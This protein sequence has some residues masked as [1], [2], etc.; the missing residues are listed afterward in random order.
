MKLFPQCTFTFA[1]CGEG[2]KGS[3]EAGAAPEVQAMG[4]SPSHH[5]YSGRNVFSFRWYI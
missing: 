4:L 3:W 1:F 5:M 2:A